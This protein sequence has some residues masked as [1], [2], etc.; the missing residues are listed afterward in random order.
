MHII[1]N[2]KIKD[3]IDGI[4]QIISPGTH[5]SFLE[6]G[7]IHKLL[8]LG[9]HHTESGVFGAEGL[10]SRD[11]P[12]VPLNMVVGLDFSIDDVAGFE[13]LEKRVL[14]YLEKPIL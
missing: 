8:Q 7:I 2:P 9:I 13:V 1:T 6:T 3:L 14:H 4:Q 11:L 5:R 10:L 12:F